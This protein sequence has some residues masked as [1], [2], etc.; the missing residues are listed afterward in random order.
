MCKGDNSM[1][2]NVFYQYNIE[3]T[4]LVP[5]SQKKSVFLQCQLNQ[6]SNWEYDGKRSPSPGQM[7]TYRDS[8]KGT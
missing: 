2:P 3:V 5:P 6:L 8:S 7:D 4:L 1:R